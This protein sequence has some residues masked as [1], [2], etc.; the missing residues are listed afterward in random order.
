MSYNLLAEG[1]LDYEELAI[2][3]ARYPALELFPVPAETEDDR[4]AMGI[5]LPSS[6]ANEDGAAEMQQLIRELWRTK[7]QIFDLYVG[8]AI[9]TED[10]LRTLVDRL[11]G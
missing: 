10:D 7:L 2:L 6:R 4:D 1:S 8:S 3:T 5:A 9:E 11:V